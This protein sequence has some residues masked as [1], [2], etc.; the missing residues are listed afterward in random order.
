M[1]TFTLSAASYFAASF[2]IKFVMA[3]SCLCVAS[4]TYSEYCAREIIV[5][6]SKVTFFSQR[7]GLSR[8]THLWSV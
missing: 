8:A 1:N 2:T 4:A 7:S 5:T 3:N 6:R